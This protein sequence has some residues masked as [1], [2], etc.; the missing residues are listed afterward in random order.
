MFKQHETFRNPG[1]SWGGELFCDESDGHGLETAEVQVVGV[2][3]HSILDQTELELETDL[4]TCNVRHL[5]LRHKSFAP[6]SAEKGPNH[7]HDKESHRRFID[8]CHTAKS[9][10]RMAAVTSS[11]IMPHL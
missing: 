8:D 4:V 1:D 7:R 11:L 9:Y 2:Y 6:T 5:G 3:R 10:H